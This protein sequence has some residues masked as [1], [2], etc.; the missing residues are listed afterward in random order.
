MRQ[1]DSV[2]NELRHFERNRDVRIL[3]A[4]DVGPRSWGIMPEV[5]VSDV[6]FVYVRPIS[7]YLLLDEPPADFKWPTFDGISSFGHDLRKFL[8]DLKA[9]D[10]FS[11]DVLGSSVVYYESSDFWTLSDSQLCWFDPPESAKWHLDA[12]KEGFGGIIVADMLDLRRF[13]GVLHGV[14]ASKWCVKR[15]TSPDSDLERLMSAI[16]PVELLADAGGLVGMS[17]TGYDSVPTDGHEALLDWVS[18]EIEALPAEIG[19]YRHH[20]APGW[21]ELDRIFRRLAFV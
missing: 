14:L 18:C 4:C 10:P 7:D 1:R 11:V 6:F 19:R 9:Q 21:D 15:F 12:A 5:G 17:R 13:L 2:L 20:K 8:R 3:Y 16:L